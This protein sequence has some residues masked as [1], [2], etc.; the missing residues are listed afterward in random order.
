VGAAAA[1]TVYAPTQ[2]AQ[3]RFLGAYR[4]PRALAEALL[5]VHERLTFTRALSLGLRQSGD[6]L[7]SLTPWQSRPR[8]PHFD[9]LGA[10]SVGGRRAYLLALAHPP[11]GATLDWYLLMLK[12][13]RAWRA[14]NRAA[15]PAHLVL[16]AGALSPDAVSYL[17]RW[18]K[19]ENGG[20][21]FL[22][23][24]DRVVGLHG[25]HAGVAPL[26]AA[27]LNPLSFI[28]DLSTTPVQ[29]G[30]YTLRYWA[31]RTRGKTAG[32][33]ASF[34]ELNRPQIEAL[35]TIAK[36]PLLDRAGIKRLHPTHSLV[37]AA[38]R[39]LSSLQREALVETVPEFPGRYLPTEKG[40]RL[41]A[42]FAGVGE[43]NLDAYLGWPARPRT[44]A[45]QRRH[46][47]RILDFM[48]RLSA[49]GVLLAWDFFRSRYTYYDLRVGRRSLRVLTIHPDSAGTLLLDAGTR[50]CID[51]WLEVD[52]G[53]RRGRKLNRQLEKYFLVQYAR[54]APVSLPP[55]VYIVDT[56][57]SVEDGV[58]WDEGRL[59]SVVRR[60]T[61]LTDW[62][63]RGSCLTVLFTTGE[64]LDAHRTEQLLEARLWRM[65]RK[66]AWDPEMRS[67]RAAL[68]ECLR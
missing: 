16:G 55:L 58:G 51:F 66:T 45:L 20:V 35:E 6:L 63:Y 37:N 62:R 47:L 21:S 40:I 44:F 43:K 10:V 19:A 8:G 46:T 30:R 38:G 65:F 27:A 34:L 18:V 36:Y 13:W 22:G 9:L 1:A 50:L 23:A 14:D 7:W 42:A 29:V 33:A 11:H 4:S 60:L 32:V 15:L 48:L 59:R 25:S 2:E 61:A 57:K 26:P 54:V 53:T 56:R 67:L 3:S 52:R 28:A 24:H 49:E 12:T 68:A 64:L 31:R 5:L 39:H 41:L 17:G